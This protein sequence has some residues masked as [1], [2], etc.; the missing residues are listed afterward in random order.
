MVN[1][2]EI[3][4]L[5]TTADQVDEPGEGY[6]ASKDFTSLACWQ[7]ARALKLFFFQEILPLIP[8]SEKFNLDIQ[9]R[10][11]IVSGTANIAEGYGRFHHREGIQFYRIS[12]GSIYELKDHL[13]TCKDYGYINNKK[14]EKGLSL[15]EDAKIALNGYI[16]YKKGLL[17]K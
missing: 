8:S 11:A 14:Y 6:N 1:S 13:I 4:E 5:N 3:K 12:R 15:I 10:K 17:N 2:E 16:R 9:I 7:K